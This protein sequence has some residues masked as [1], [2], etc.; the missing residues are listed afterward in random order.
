MSTA[1]LSVEAIYGSG[2]LKF[3]P[4]HTHILLHN[5]LSLQASGTYLRR[6]FS[7]LHLAHHNS[8]VP[9]AIAGKGVGNL[10]SRTF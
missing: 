7:S 4:T 1:S 8:H 10:Q 6:P 9:T 3:T 2:N 5:L